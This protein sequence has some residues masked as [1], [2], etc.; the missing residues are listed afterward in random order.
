MFLLI[1]HTGYVILKYESNPKGRIMIMARTVS[2]G[3]QSFSQ[4]REEGSFLIDKTMLIKDWWDNKDSVTLIA[5]PRRFGKTLN[6]NMLECFFST[7]YSGR[8]DLF[9]GMDIWDYEEFRNLQGTYPVISLSFAKLKN[10][11]IDEMKADFC[12]IITELLKRHK[13]T[14]YGSEVLDQDDKDDFRDILYLIN[15]KKSYSEAKNA[16]AF[17]SSLLEKHYGKPVIIL[18]DEY[19][20]PL[21]EAYIGGFWNELVSFMRLFFNSTFKDNKYMYR[22]VMTGITRV[23][24]ESLFSDMNNLELCTLSSVKYSEYFGF[25][26]EEVFAS[27]DEFGYTNKDEVKYWYDGF[28][29]GD[30]TDIYNPWSV[31]NFLDKGSLDTYWANTSS[32]SLVSSLIREADEEIKSDFEELLSGGTIVKT[33]DD[34]MVFSQLSESINSIWSLLSS[35]GY[36]KMKNVSEDL[37][38]LQIVN[39]EVLKMFRNMVEGW[40]TSKTSKYSKLI[41]SLL[42]VQLEDLNE[43]MNILTES[44]MSSFDTGENPNDFLAPE[45]FYHGFVLGLLVELRDSYSVKSNRESGIGRYD[46]MLIPKNRNDRAFII[47]FKS[48]NRNRG[49]KSLENAL[50]NALKQIEEF[51]YQQNLIDLGIPEENIVK[52]GFAFEGKKVLIGRG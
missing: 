23:S 18:L 35:S 16:V 40:F 29:V 52:Y 19:D 1:N 11:S 34:E 26:E 21:Q 41:K 13:E 42:S 28:T 9:E 7:E 33:V 10:N 39:Y 25:T 37:Y 5:R 14:V 24:R 50:T 46:V 44:L 43:Y 12:A 8:A 22:S 47:E 30:K 31:I 27:M 15:R 45:K 6:M 36:L 32:N 3:T 17:L 38:E 2:V 49:E 4:I 48:V 20:T 51:R